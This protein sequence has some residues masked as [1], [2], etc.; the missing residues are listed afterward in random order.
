VKQAK[1]RAK[2]AEPPMHFIHGDDIDVERA[3]MRQHRAQDWSQ[4]KMRTREVKRF[5]PGA[6]NGVSEL[7]HQGR[8]AGR[9]EYGSKLANER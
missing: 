8:G 7:V 3:K 9:L 1:R 6:D 5:Q 2:F 4:Q